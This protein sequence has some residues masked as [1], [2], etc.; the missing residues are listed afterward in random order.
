[1]LPGRCHVIAAAAAFRFSP[2]TL[3]SCHYAS[4]H[5]DAAIT[6]R[7]CHYAPCAATL[8]YVLMRYDISPQRR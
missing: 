6:P 8:R 1:M 4:R 7:R 5:A 3:L 2:L